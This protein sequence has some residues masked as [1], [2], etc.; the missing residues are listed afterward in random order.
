M[1]FFLILNNSLEI[2]RVDIDLTLILCF[3]A[4]FGSHRKE[5]ESGFQITDPVLGYEY[6]WT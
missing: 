4:S 5:V 3:C 2:I 1:F 6:R